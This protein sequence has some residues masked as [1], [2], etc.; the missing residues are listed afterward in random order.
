LLHVW[1]CFSCLITNS[2]GLTVHPLQ[3]SYWNLIVIV[4][5]LKDVTFE[6]WLG[7]K[8]LCPQDGASSA[9]LSCSLGPPAHHDGAGWSSPDA[10]TQIMDSRP[11]ELWGMNSVMILDCIKAVKTGTE[12]HRGLFPHPLR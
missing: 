9:L 10:S 7:P 3:N 2:Y 8:G 4:T 1:F 12:L 6:R 11:P 5:I